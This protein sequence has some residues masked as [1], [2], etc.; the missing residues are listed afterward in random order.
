MRSNGTPEDRVGVARVLQQAGH[1]SGG[2]PVSEGCLMAVVPY[3]LRVTL[4]KYAG[5]KGRARPLDEAW[6]EGLF[7]GTVRAV[8]G[9]FVTVVWDV[10]GGEQLCPGRELLLV[11]RYT[12][13]GRGEF[14]GQTRQRI[15]AYGPSTLWWTGVTE[16]ELRSGSQPR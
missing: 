4:A 13:Y 8:E 12:Q 5:V 11:H 7:M 16:D 15:K 1:L 3:P 10:G 14:E 6:L 2:L 9:A